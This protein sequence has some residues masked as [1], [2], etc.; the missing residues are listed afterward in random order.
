MP[1]GIA[2][3]SVCRLEGNVPEIF[4]PKCGELTAP[5]QGMLR[6]SGN[7][8]VAMMLRAEAN[9]TYVIVFSSL[10]FTCKHRCLERGI[11]TSSCIKK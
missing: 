6:T 8:V 10:S 9:W 1:L 3:T 11:H 7:S 2:A 4:D 5:G